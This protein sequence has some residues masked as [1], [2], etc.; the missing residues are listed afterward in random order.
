[1]HFACT[2]VA[3]PSCFISP[4]AIQH[5]WQVPALLC[6]PRVHACYCWEVV[7]GFRWTDG[8]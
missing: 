5:I 6:C 3:V 7:A 1:M 2:Y 8:F 4:V